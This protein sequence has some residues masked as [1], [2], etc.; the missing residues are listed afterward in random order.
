MFSFFL[1][2]SNIVNNGLAPSLAYGEL[3]NN[4]N[5]KKFL[6]QIFPRIHVGK[7]HAFMVH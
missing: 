7:R 3:L 4:P 2:E 6:H 1:T 5:Y